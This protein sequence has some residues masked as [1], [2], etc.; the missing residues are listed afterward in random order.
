MKK[1]LH[2]IFYIFL[3]ILAFVLL[4]FFFIRSTFINFNVEN[5][6]GT[7][8]AIQNY[9][10][11]VDKYADE[12]KLPASYLM[13]LIMLECSGAKVIKPRF[14]QHVYLKLKKFR[15]GQINK[16][17]D[18]SPSDLKGMSDSDLKE[19]AKS[20]GPFQ[21]MGY[22]SIKLGCSVRDLYDKDAIKFGVKWIDNE[23]GDVV[24]EGRFLDAFHLHNT[25]KVFP[26]SG[27][28]ETYDPEYVDNGIYYIRYFSSL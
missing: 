26:Q 21:I 19:L 8:A 20:Y 3:V 15:D 17:E 25:G 5:Y 2:K 28:S 16:F 13:S 7:D 18:L 14:E 23:Y 27:K 9:K 12:Y 24:R 11:D 1:K 22:K 6:M 10:S 4:L